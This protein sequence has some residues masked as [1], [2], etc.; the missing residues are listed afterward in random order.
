MMTRL[1]QSNGF[2]LDLNNI[3]AIE[4]IVS[5]FIHIHDNTKTL[6]NV[7]KGSSKEISHDKKNFNLLYN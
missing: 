2:K 7:K 5:S 6:Q 3:Q 4:Q 1:W